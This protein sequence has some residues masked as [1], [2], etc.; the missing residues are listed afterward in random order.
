MAVRNITLTLPDDLVRR[1]KV[2]AAMRD[3]SVSALVA[4]YFEALTRQEDDYDLMWREERRLMEEGL[5]MRVGEVTWSR[6]D[7][8]ER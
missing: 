2:V 3:T 1:A 4:E 7:T 5:A 8:H 6:A